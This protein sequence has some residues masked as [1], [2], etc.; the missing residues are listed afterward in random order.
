MV[1]SISANDG[2]FSLSTGGNVNSGVGTSG[3]DGAPADSVNLVIT[4]V[5]GDNDPRL[6]EVGDAYDL[7][8]GNDP[9]GFSIDNAVVIRSDSTPTGVGGGIVF[10][11]LDASGALVQVIWTPDFDLTGWYADATAGGGTAGFYTS[12]QDPNY[13]HTYVCFAADTCIATPNGPMRARDI[14]AGDRINTRDHGAKRVLWVGNRRARGIGRNAP[15]YFA[16]GSI[17]NRKPLRLSQQHRVLLRSP[18]A[19]LYFGTKEVLVPAKSLINGRNIYLRPCADINY[20][21][22][23]FKEHHILSENGVPCESLLLG[24]VA[25]DLVRASEL[26]V[27]AGL[28]VEIR[29]QKAARPILTMQEARLVAGTIGIALTP[30]PAMATV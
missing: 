5:E 21:H 20:V 1:F 24:N 15:V 9:G 28:A 4:T 16:A 7:S 14:A 3:F 22:L 10:E 2:E 25:A 17:G 19:E 30:E 12:D 6:F 26:D 11:G 8:W 27:P 29:Q 18:L 13:T 23:L